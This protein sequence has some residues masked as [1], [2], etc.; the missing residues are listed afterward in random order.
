MEFKGAIAIIGTGAVGGYYGAL[1]QKAGFPVHFLLHSDC[2]H[3]RKHGLVIQSPHGDFHLERVA[4]YDT[5]ES[6]PRCDLVVV[7]LKTTANHLLPDLLPAVVRDDGL[8]LTLQNGMGSEEAIAAC[9]GSDRILSGLCFLCSNK[10][11]PGCIRHL[12]YGLVTLGDYRADHRPAGITPRLEALRT[13]LQSAGIPV[14]TIADLQL[15]R[16]KKLVWNIPF[17]GLTVVHRA[18]TRPLLEDAGI[19]RRCRTL[20]QEVAQAAAACA[21]P[22]E[23]AFIEKMMSDTDKMKPY[24]PS[25]MLDYERGRPMEIE[26]IYGIGVFTSL[27]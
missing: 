24:A 8:V 25:M 20:M 6:M 23:E 7:A 2:E 19:R 15:G 26:S 13:V 21:R 9:V 5:A 18:L 14:E 27:D 22:I 10:V 11:A 17:N 3:V 16:W 12:D 1:L 4:A